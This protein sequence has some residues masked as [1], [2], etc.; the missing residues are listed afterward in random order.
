MEDNHTCQAAMEAHNDFIQSTLTFLMNQIP[1]TNHDKNTGHP[2]GGTHYNGNQQAIINNPP[3]SIW[4]P[5]LQLAFFEGPE[6][7]DWLFQPEQ[8]FS[9]YQIPPEQRVSM[10]SFHMK[11]ET[12]NWFKWLHQNN[13]IT[14]RTSFTQALELR[15]GSST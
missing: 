14:D 7:I 13:L 4:P 2:L 3:L 1:S 6:P 8:Y 15:F 5:K 10:V 11:G 9:F 12:L